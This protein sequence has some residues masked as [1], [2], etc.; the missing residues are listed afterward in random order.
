MAS[1]LIYGLNKS[2]GILEAIML[3][4]I[5]HQRSGSHGY[6]TEINF[7]QHFR[8]QVEDKQVLEAWINMTTDNYMSPSIQN[9]CLKVMG[10]NILTMVGKNVRGNAVC[11]SIIAD[12]C[13][14]I[15]NKEQFTI[16]LR[17]VGRDLEDCEDFIGLCQVNSITADSLTFHI[18]DALLPLNVK[19]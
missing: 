5:T 1:N 4:I 14:D 11:F 2:S 19:L 17:W 12:G 10:S 8:L 16:Y 9:E 13:T 18:K 3:D 6:D 7:F 15:A